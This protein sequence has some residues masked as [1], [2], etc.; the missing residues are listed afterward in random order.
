VIYKVTGKYDRASERGVIW[1]D[2][3]LKLPWPVPASGPVLSDKD[4]V[5]PRLGECPIWFRA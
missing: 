5:L 2:P 4:Q 1:N 3:D